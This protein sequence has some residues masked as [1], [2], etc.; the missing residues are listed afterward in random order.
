MAAVLKKVRKYV[1][2]TMAPYL[3]L[4]GMTSRPSMPIV[5]VSSPI[6]STKIYEKKKEHIHDLTQ[7]S[8]RPDTSISGLYVNDFTQIVIKMRQQNKHM[9]VLGFS[10][11][12]GNKVCEN[13]HRVKK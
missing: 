8:F 4:F 12:L 9:Y 3:K 5:S 1:F 6:T 7:S 2:F 10:A 13:C 11:W